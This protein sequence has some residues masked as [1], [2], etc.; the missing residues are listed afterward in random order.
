MLQTMS[1]VLRRTVIL[2]GQKVDQSV[3]ER[4]IEG[5]EEWERD[6]RSE[7]IRSVEMERS[8]CLH[9]PL[10][11]NV[12]KGLTQIFEKRERDEF[13][14]I[15]EIDEAVKKVFK[16]HPIVK[17]TGKYELEDTYIPDPNFTLSDYHTDRWHART[18]VMILYL[19]GPPRRSRD[20][21]G[22]FDGTTYLPGNPDFYCNYKSFG[23][24][25]PSLGE[26]TPPTG[27]SPPGAEYAKQNKIRTLVTPGDVCIHNIWTCHAAPVLMKGESRRVIRFF[28]KCL[29]DEDTLPTEDI[30]YD[31]ATRLSKVTFWDKV[32]NLFFST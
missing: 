5:E 6:A 13:T 26:E 15:K 19:D 7:K 32:Y 12:L 14:D 9:N 4:T 18:I 16:E 11:P 22:R 24:E 3:K 31:F 2:P 20:N 8:V 25:T 23:N 17:L 27:S 28:W 21:P 30:V 10:S 29:V 1:V